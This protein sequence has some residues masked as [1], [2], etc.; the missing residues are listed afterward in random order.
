MV[1]VKL[2][3]DVELKRKKLL[4]N[5]QSKELRVKLN[6]KLKRKKQMRVP[7]PL[8]KLLITKRQSITW[9]SPPSWPLFFPN[10]TVTNFSNINLLP[11]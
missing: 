5:E 10:W 3:S 6:C 1:D 7:K 11:F 2:S 4:K 9:K 8:L